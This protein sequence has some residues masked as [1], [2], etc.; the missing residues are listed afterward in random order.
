MGYSYDM[1]G[2]LCCDSCG[3][4]GD[5]RKRTCPHRVQYADGG[6]LPYCYPSA[7]CKA[8][9]AKHKATLHARCAEGAAQSNVREQARKARL[10]AGALERRACWGSWHATVPD[11]MVGVYFKGMQGEAWRLVTHDAY[12]TQRAWLDEYPDAQPW[13]VHA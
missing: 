7:L 6:S 2:R 5:A 9:Y 4:S 1:G 8:C 12:D 13:E 10:V 11:G 3:A